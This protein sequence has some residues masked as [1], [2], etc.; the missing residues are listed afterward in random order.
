MTTIQWRPEVNA[1]TIPQSYRLRFLP[2]A[3]FGYEELTAEIVRDNPTWNESLVEAVLRVRDEKVKELLINGNQVT[4]EDTFSYRLSFHARLESPND[5]PPPPEESVRVKISA[6]RPFV[7][8]VRRNARL[9]RQPSEEK[10]PLIVSTDDTDLELKDVLYNEGVLRLTGND[11]L[12]DRKD[13]DCGCVIEGTRSGSTTQQQYAQISNSTILLVPAMPPQPDPWNNEYTVSVTTHY[14]EHGTPRTGTYR[15]RLRSILS[16]TAF[17]QPGGNDVGILTGSAD[18]PYVTVTGGTGSTDERLRIQ[19]IFDLSEDCL[20]FNLLDM[21]KNG[22][23][24]ATVTVT[25]NGD[26]TLSGF[27]S[28]AVTDMTIRVNNYSDLAQMVRNDYSSR[29][30]DIL[31]VEL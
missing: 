11:L 15:R 21:R 7:K 1:L 16:V 24:G 5:P 22:E 12:F 31:D 9:E 26:Y 23:A 28:S 30:V 13:P 25:A 29:L 8:D 27:S 2:R 17:G 14:T 6:S 10:L 19:V 3:V 18:S 4:L 20:F